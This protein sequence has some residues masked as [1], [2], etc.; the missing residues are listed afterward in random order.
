MATRILTSKSIAKAEQALE[1]AETWYE[2]NRAK[3]GNVNTNIMCVGVAIGELLKDDFPL[4]DEVVKSDNGSQVR[5]LSGSMIARV[6]KEHGEER[7]FT[8]EGGRTSRGSLHKA[9][10]LA[11]ILNALFEEGLTEEDRLAVAKILEDYFVRKIQLDYFD[12]QRMKVDIDCAKP[13][14]GI[15]ADI[16]QVAKG[17]SDK[18][19]GI[20][21]QHLVGAKLE[22]RFPG[23]DV[24][25]DKA[26]AAD[27]QTD[28]QGDFQLGT[29]A[30]H[31]TVSPMPKLT[32][33]ARE[34]LREGY[35][36]VVLVPF[37][38]MPF[39]IGLF[40]SEGL[41]DRVGVESIESFVGMTVEEMGGF[42]SANIR[43]GVA[44]FVRRYNERIYSCETDKSLMIEEPRWMLDIVGKWDTSETSYAA[45]KI[46]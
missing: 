38:K 36:P 12:K 22:L 1:A 4:T 30:F 6:L 16:L 2:G 21:A 29:T 20:V 31:V 15:V 44:R 33:R 11:G 9:L 26:N 41:G 14:S 3:S 19:T 37:D 8:S 13:V 45:V 24:G 39:A 18:P 46:S 40:E 10:E 23:L 25:R 42:D 34:N 43:S 17:R 27:Q 32:A 7:E 5:G 28:R 35:R